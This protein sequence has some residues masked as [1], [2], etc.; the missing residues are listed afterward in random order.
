MHFVI[1][2][3]AIPVGDVEIFDKLN[4]TTMK[5]G[6]Y[7][8]YGKWFHGW[9]TNIGGPCYEIDFETDVVHD[10]YA[11]G[12][13]DGY[14]YTI[15]EDNSIKFMLHGGE[16]IIQIGEFKKGVSL[17]TLPTIPWSSNEC[18]GIKDTRS[19]DQKHRNNFILDE[20]Y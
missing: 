9:L 12:T 17:K 7:L 14:K 11:S 1:Y 4:L 5:V 3:F 2:I 15:I 8:K 16:A 6:Q 20:I 18:T 13:L 19:V 10:N